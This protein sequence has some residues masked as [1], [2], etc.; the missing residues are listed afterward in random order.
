M[1]FT[2]TQDLKKVIAQLVKEEKTGKFPQVITF[3]R[4]LEYPKFKITIEEI[5]E[6]FFIDSKGIKWVKAKEDKENK[7]EASH[8]MKHHTMKK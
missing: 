5:N 1:L 7:E 6:D 3:S 2:K 8:D 4:G